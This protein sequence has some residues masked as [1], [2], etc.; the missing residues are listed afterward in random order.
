[1]CC[2]LLP[3]SV[4]GNLI[5]VNEFFGKKGHPEVAEEIFGKWLPAAMKAETLKRLPVTIVGDG[6]E[7]IARAMDMMSE[8]VSAQKLVVTLSQDL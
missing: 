2:L 1:M 6:W 4:S 7:T 8:G 5:T 3:F